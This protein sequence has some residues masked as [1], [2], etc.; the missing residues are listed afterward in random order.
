MAFCNR[1]IPDVVTDTATS[2]R[3]PNT[4]QPKMF[5]LYVLRISK[6]Q[7]NNA[8]RKN[9]IKLKKIIEMLAE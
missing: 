5:K 2:C 4:V 8:I 6:F 9:D 7:C 1:V 3:Q